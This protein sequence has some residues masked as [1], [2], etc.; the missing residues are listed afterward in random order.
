[1]FKFLDLHKGSMCNWLALSGD[2][3]MMSKRNNLKS[4]LNEH[5]RWIFSH[6]KAGKLA[7]IKN[8]KLDKF[9]LMNEDLPFAKLRSISL[10][11]ANLAG[12]NFRQADLLQG[13]FVGAYL[14]DADLSG[15]NLSGGDFSFSKCKGTNFSNANLEGTNFEGADLTET[16][17]SKAIL[18]CANFKGANLLTAELV[19]AD[20]EGANFQDADLEGTKFEGT[21]VFKATFDKTYLRNLDIK[22]INLAEAEHENANYSKST[23]SE[24]KLPKIGLKNHLF[25]KTIPNRKPSIK[26]SKEDLS[27]DL[28]AVNPAMVEGAINDLIKKLKSNIQLE[29]VKEICKHQNIIESI[30]KV[31]FTNG[32]IVTHDGQVVFKLDFNISYNLSLLLDRKGKLINVRRTIT[33]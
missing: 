31:D 5:S 4:I 17:F 14:D 24:A 30:D 18:R 27:V 3:L 16:N 6:G 22:N 2:N 11:G 25:D 8:W 23:Q 13:S 32:D 20:I 19:D 9:N 7:D 10:K 21:N 29:Q 12:I 28:N 33:K 26:S 1:M 15:A